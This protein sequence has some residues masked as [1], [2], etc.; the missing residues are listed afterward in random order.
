MDIPVLLVWGEQDDTVPFEHH[1]RLLKAIPQAQFHPIADSGHI[2]HYEHA[3]QVNPK[4]LRFLN[5]E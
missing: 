3:E 1:R 2:P 5:D 4:I